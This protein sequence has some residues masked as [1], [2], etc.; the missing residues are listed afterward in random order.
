MNF[1]IHYASLLVTKYEYSFLKKINH[2]KCIKYQKKTNSNLL[3]IRCN[4]S[5]TLQMNMSGN[6]HFDNL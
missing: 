5:L 1:I 3:I 4:N 2:N 6:F